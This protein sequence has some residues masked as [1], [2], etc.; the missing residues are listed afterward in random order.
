MDTPKLNEFIEYV[1]RNRYEAECK[2]QESLLEQSS[3]ILVFES[4]LTASVFMVWPTLLDV[5][6]CSKNAINIF[7]LAFAIQTVMVLVVALI[8][9]WRIRHGTFPDPEKFIEHVNTN[10]YTEDRV[11]AF[12]KKHYPAIIKSYTKNNDIRLVLVNIC[13]VIL[14]IQF[15]TIIGITAHIVLV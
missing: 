5:F 1:L 9:Q 10:G 13:H 12:Y 2:R 15:L 11:G 7:I 8:S 6:Q 3:R 4:L 14:F